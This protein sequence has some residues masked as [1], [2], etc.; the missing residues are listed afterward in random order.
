METDLESLSSS[1]ESLAFGIGRNRIHGGAWRPDPD[2]P[3]AFYFIGLLPST[4]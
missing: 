4:R 2:P 1:D 3:G